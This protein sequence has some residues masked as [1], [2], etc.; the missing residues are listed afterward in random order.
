MAD[1]Y[2]VLGIKRSASADEIK[3]A[4][5]KK[6]KEH[7]PDVGGDG[8]YILK[9]N[10][11]W[12]VLGD[13]DKKRAYDNQI[14]SFSTPRNASYSRQAAPSSS[15]S[16][17]WQ[18]ATSDNWT[19]RRASD[20]QSR[21]RAGSST[22]ASREY[23]SVRKNTFRQICICGC[24]GYPMTHL[25]WSIDYSKYSACPARKLRKRCGFYYNDS[26]SYVSWDSEKTSRWRRRNEARRNPE[27]AREAKK[28]SDKARR[29]AEKS[30]RDAIARKKEQERVKNSMEPLSVAEAKRR[31]LK[32]YRGKPCKYGHNS[33]RDLN[34]NCLRCR[35]LEKL[36]RASEKISQNQQNSVLSF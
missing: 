3:R 25:S 35:E 26:G 4:F 31:G 5:R 8:I 21:S 22:R 34:S 36:K 28:K 27:A 13:P 23:E 19:S 17:N 9:I 20:Y 15:W 30:A 10:D 1:H 16:A 29:E 24:R 33:L 18:R 32:Y 11:A 12:E 14:S 2:S 6:A 7:H